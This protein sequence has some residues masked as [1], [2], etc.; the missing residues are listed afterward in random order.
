MKYK[1]FETRLE[2]TWNDHQNY[3]GWRDKNEITEKILNNP[4]SL[5][6]KTIGYYSGED[7]RS[8]LISQSIDEQ[9]IS[10]NLQILKCDILTIRE[11]KK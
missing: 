8:I 2:V 4:E 10:N 11:I 1:K 6:V 7:E 9:N 5:K 3:T